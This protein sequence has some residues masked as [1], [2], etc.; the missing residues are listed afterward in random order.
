MNLKFLFVS[1]LLFLSNLFFAF[2]GESDFRP[3]NRIDEIQ[4]S[5][6]Q[7]K[8][9][10]PAKI[11]SDSIFIRR[12]YFDLCGQPPPYER[13]KLFIEDK[14]PDKRNKLVEDLLSTDEFAYYWALRWGDIL[15][16]KSEF[17]INIWPNAVQSFSYWLFDSIRENKPYDIFC[18]EM[19]CASGSNF[20]VPPVNFYRSTPDKTP[21]GIAKIAVLAFLCSRIEKWNDYEKKEISKIFSRVSYKK[22]DEWKEEIVFSNPT[23]FESFKV[24]MPDGTILEMSESIDPRIQFADWL[25][26]PAKKWFAEAAVN[27]IWFWLFGR[28]IIHEPDDFRFERENSFI[29]ALLPGTVI[30]NNN[31]A[32][33]PV[34]PELL[35]YL[36]DEF[37]R[38]NYD[39]KSFVKLI[40]SSATYQQSCI[41]TIELQLAEKY[42]AVYKVRRLDAEIIA[43]ILSYYSKKYPR[44]VSM[45]PEPFTFIPSENPTIS[46]ND[47]SITSS[48]LEL[49]GRSPR[50]SGLL[51]EKNNSVTYAQRLYFLNSSDVQNRLCSSPLLKYAFTNAGPDPK[52]I[53]EEIYLLYLS[54]YP[55]QKEVKIILEKINS[56][57]GEIRNFSK[58][59][60][61]NLRPVIND[62]VWAL[63]NSEEF[64]FRH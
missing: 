52:R 1:F 50:D 64:I 23:P 6:F 28:G 60:I 19:I 46:L 43:D 47:G 21:E 51:L 15:R 36:S 8:D 35:N 17:P 38:N 12:V 11:C 37:I 31:K 61:K 49:F 44:Y 59:S 33:K 39:F 22:T 4:L 56:E 48:F 13:V 9:I 16:I 57:F 3:L 14:N 24:N 55:T 26:G 34:N 7:K 45:I 63:V 53:I 27:R 25:S 41:P 29:G 10:K 42:F 2:E 5:L 30:R 32:N 40:V 58:K 62:I 20:R 54:R 18:R